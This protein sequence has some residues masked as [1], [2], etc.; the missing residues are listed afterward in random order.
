MI[1]TTDPWIILAPHLS[2]PTL[3]A[4]CTTGKHIIHFWLSAPSSQHQQPLTD[5]QTLFSPT[6]EILFD[7]K[8]AIKHPPDQEL[9]NCHDLDAFDYC[10]SVCDRISNVSAYCPRW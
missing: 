2:R 3:A 9:R 4:L 5:P 8:I 10:I 7:L 6:Q 1:H